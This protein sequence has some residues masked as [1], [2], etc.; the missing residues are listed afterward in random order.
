MAGK[1]AYTDR[2]LK[3]F[4]LRVAAKLDG[5]RPTVESITKYSQLWDEPCYATLAKRFGPKLTGMLKQ[6]PKF[7]EKH[8]APLV[9]IEVAEETK[10][11]LKIAQ[12]IRGHK[13][14]EDTLRE[15][16]ELYLEHLTK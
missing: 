3:N 9:S 1:P 6:A 5:K 16:A 7:I 13:K 15:A 8:G 12:K 2:Y 4:I 11:R 14:L 10:M